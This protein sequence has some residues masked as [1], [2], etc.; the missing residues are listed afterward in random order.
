MARSELFQTNQSEM[1]LLNHSEFV[2]KQVKLKEEDTLMMEQFGS[3]FSFRGKFFSRG[4]A[5]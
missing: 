5:L 4:T 1:K 2:V 3:V